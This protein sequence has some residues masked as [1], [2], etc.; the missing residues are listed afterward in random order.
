MME[1]LYLSGTI[2]I[3]LSLLR[4]GDHKGET[5]ALGFFYCFL[6][7]DTQGQI[8]TTIDKKFIS[9]VLSI[10]N[11][12]KLPSKIS[13]HY[14]NGMVGTLFGL[15]MHST[16]RLE[17]IDQGGV[18]AL[19]NIKKEQPIT[20]Y[21]GTLGIAF[22]MSG[23]TFKINKK[24]KTTCLNE[25]TYF[26]KTTTPQEL[27][28]LEGKDVFL[29]TSFT[30]FMALVESKEIA[31]QMIGCLFF[32]NVSSTDSN[33][34]VLEAEKLKGPLICLQWHPDVRISKYGTT[35]ANNFGSYVPSL[36]DLCHFS[37][38]HKYKHL[39]PKYLK[40]LKLH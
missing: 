23:D 34:K 16:T 10:A 7:F 14:Y 5:T 2:N 9:T 28:K 38:K 19:L 33:K 40:L 26:T 12:K 8:A 21:L 3:M 24:K 18:D 17:L 32:A 20:K 11:K 27:S 31:V 29:W 25:L 1:K 39:M 13:R 4:S 37:I 36:S 6:E 30:R 35:I 15:S 22:L